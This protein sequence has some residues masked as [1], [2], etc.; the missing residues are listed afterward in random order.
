MSRQERGFV[1]HTCAAG[2]ER[3]GVFFIEKVAAAKTKRTSSPENKKLNP[4]IN[5]Y[6][7]PPHA[8]VPENHLVPQI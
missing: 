8:T 1:Y 5:P 6:P 4:L 3:R 2:T 7:P